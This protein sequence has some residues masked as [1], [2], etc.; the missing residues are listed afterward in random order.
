[1]S[2]IQE[3]WWKDWV[4]SNS[5]DIVKFVYPPPIKMPSSYYNMMKFS[6]GSAEYSPKDYFW[7]VKLIGS[8]FTFS[9]KFA[10]KLQ[11]SR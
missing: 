6:I 11:N 4:F 1:M 7:E 10:L 9:Q 5:K 8:N 3:I 2:Q